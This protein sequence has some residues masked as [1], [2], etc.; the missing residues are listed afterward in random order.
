M[1]FWEFGDEGLVLRVR[2]HPSARRNEV[3]G[4]HGDELS[5]AVTQAPEKG[6]ANKAVVELLAKTLSVKRSQVELV[7]GAT[8]SSKRLVVRG[9][10]EN[11]WK[12]RLRGLLLTAE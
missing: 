4:V 11:E 3:R 9:L 2:V 6:K 8:A 12:E 10:N 5:I 1:T 7:S